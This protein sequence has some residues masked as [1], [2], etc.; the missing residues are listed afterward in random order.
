MPTLED[1]LEENII[2]TI[3]TAPL[4]SSELSLCFARL[5]EYV[6]NADH[7]VHI[8][9]DIIE[10][11]GIPAQAPLLFIRARIV[12]KPDPGSMAVIGTNPLAQILT[13]TAVTM[14]G[15]NILFFATKTEALE[16]LHSS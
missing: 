13:Q 14:T 1:W 4:K 9:F 3:W 15:Q 10:A 5:A 6:E 16:Y 7:V 8:L 11:G 12:T 2:S